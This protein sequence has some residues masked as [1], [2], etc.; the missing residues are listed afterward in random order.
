M[1]LTLAIFIKKTTNVLDLILN[2]H[3][4]VDQLLVG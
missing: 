4:L 3:K 2:P 1:A